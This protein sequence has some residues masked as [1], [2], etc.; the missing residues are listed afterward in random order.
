MS[1]AER[2]PYLFA[3]ST[4]SIQLPPSPPPSDLMETSAVDASNHDHESN[5]HH[6]TTPPNSRLSQ[7]SHHTSISQKKS[8]KKLLHK[9]KLEKWNPALTL[10]NAGSVARDHLAS[11]RTFLAYVRTS[12]TIVSTGV[13]LV[14]LF[15]IA[16]T[17]NKALTKYSRPLGAT[18]VVI[19]VCTL[20]LGVVRYFTVQGALVDG[21]FPVARVNPALLS[22]SLLAVVLV[23]FGIL[24][25]V[26]Q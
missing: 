13:A 24:L 5:D 3:P 22:L 23:I 9:N 10:E 17:S 19:G 26:R 6:P 12:L 7:I 25:G 16:S 11:E 18:I 14:Q 15:T 1:L 21:K 20:V 8:K 4:S 2:F